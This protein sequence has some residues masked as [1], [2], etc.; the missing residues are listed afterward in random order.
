MQATSSLKEALSILSKSSPYAVSTLRKGEQSQKQKDK[1]YLYVKSP[2]DS[3]FEN[4]L[5]NAKTGSLFFLCGSSGDGKSEILTKLCNDNRFSHIEFHLDATHSKTQHGSAVDCLNDLFDRHSEESFSVAVGI[6]IGM[7]Q[8]F[9][10]LGAD[11]HGMIKELFRKFFNNR[12]VIGYSCDIATFFDFECYPRITFEN[13]EITSNFISEFLRNLTRDETNNPFWN[14]YLEDE[15]AG[16]KV[17]KNYKLL[18]DESIQNSIIKELGA[19]RLYDEQFLVPRTFVDFVYK[20]IT[21][22]NPDGLIGNL[23]DGL[24]NEISAKIIKHDPLLKRSKA[25]DDYLLAKTTNT[26]GEETIDCASFLNSIA[27]FSLSSKGQIRLTCLLREKVQQTHP[28]SLFAQLIDVPEKGQYLEL[29]NIYSKKVID[30]NAEEKLIEI[31]EENFLDAVFKYVNRSINQEL[32]GY[33]LSREVGDFYICSK[34]DIALNID[35]IEKGI[36]QAP[37]FLKVPFIV[38]D[39]VEIF[40]EIDIKLLTLTNRINMGFLPNRN[41]QNEFAKLDEF[42]RDLISAASKA[43]EIRVYD[44][45]K[46]DVFYADVKQG[47]RGYTL[48]GACR[49]D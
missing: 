3:D 7:M 38:N 10:K 31:L 21:V 35:E 49:A 34:I 44:K 1:N 29:L 40:V 5:A 12:H 9:I 26:L 15:K 24:D 22:D 14:A 20:L 33:I 13:K 45:K 25:L 37:E 43:E 23:F 42:I 4:A 8:K 28:G 11:R 48:K 17:A 41:L 6:N 19:I 32:D 47:R 30:E 16:L 36:L 18:C 39:E 46:P 27:G 2:I